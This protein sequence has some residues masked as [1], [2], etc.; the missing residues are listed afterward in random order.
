V[1]GTPLDVNEVT[2]DSYIVAGASDHI[3]PRRNAYASTQ[4][5]GGDT[6]FVQSASGHI[7]ALI[8]PP[9]PDNRSSYQL[10][11]EY[12]ANPDDESVATVTKRGSWWPDYIGWLSTRSGALKPAP[13]TLGHRQYKAQANAPGTHVPAA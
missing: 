2:V 13:T 6:R 10:A 4:L 5:L 12:P 3:V 8:K 11:D 7:R 1:L 9:G